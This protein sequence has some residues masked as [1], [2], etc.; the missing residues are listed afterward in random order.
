NMKT[1][2]DLKWTGNMAFETEMDGHKLVVDAAPSVGGENKGVRPK[3][4][5]L[6]SLAGC[7]GMDVVSILKK[8]RVEVEDLSV[9]VE[10]DMTEEHPK[11]YNKMKI[12]YSFKGNDLPREKIEKAVNL[13]EEKYCGVSA[14]YKQAMDISTEIRINE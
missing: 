14:V 11:H 6:L 8:M 12:I 13:S 9:R 4:L 5:M 7:T 3:P 10:A 2:I 1:S